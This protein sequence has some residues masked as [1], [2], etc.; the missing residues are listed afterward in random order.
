MLS[1][2]PALQCV[3]AVC[4]V[5]LTGCSGLGFF[6]ANAPNSVGSYHRTADQSYGNEAR[7]R[8]DVYSPKRS[9]LRPVVVF[10]Y[11]GTWSGGK[12]SDYSFVGAALAGQ[13]Y[14]TV[15][16][17]YRVYPEVRFPVFIEDGA[18]AVAWV[19]HH[20]RELGADPDR[21]VLMGHSAGA[22]IAALLALNPAYVTAAGV[23]PDSIAAF[24]GLS[25][26][27]ALDPD[28]DT[29]HAIFGKPYT[30]ADW[31]PVRFAHRSAPPALLLHGLND[32]IV[33]SSH[34]LQLRDALLAQGDEVET[35]FYPGRGHADTIASFSVVAR[36]RTPALKQ[37]VSFLNHITASGERPAVRP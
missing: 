30:P 29:L 4:A 12:K 15:I 26:P 11:G 9:S 21:I 33:Y 27:Y 16:P 17:D 14:L 5:A 2:S 34:T 7:Q 20:A 6:V 23:H 31:Q 37:T 28:T 19:Q 24:I 10:F 22:Q 32:K 1:R 25:G 35:H 3:M 8:L 36:L 18:K 13:G